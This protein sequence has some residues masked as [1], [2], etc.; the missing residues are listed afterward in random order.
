M[1]KLAACEGIRTCGKAIE[2]KPRHDDVCLVSASDS[3]SHGRR[4]EVYSLRRRRQDETTCRRWI[5]HPNSNVPYCQSMQLPRLGNWTVPRLR[6]S[7]VLL[8]VCS[9]QLTHL[10]GSRVVWS[11]L[12]DTASATDC[13]VNIVDTVWASFVSKSIHIPPIQPD[14][15]HVS[16]LVG[17]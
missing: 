8:Q 1:Q 10:Q 4:D 9:A 7:P 2:Q 5:H 6:I 12:N 11:S 17:E 3:T 16:T 14:R 15:M 13:Y